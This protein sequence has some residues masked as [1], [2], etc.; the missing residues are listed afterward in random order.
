M[1]ATHATVEVSSDVIVRSASAALAC[2]GL[3]CDSVVLHGSTYVA[4][5][6][7]ASFFMGMGIEVF[8]GPHGIP[9]GTQPLLVISTSGLQRD[10]CKRLLGTSRH[11][12]PLSAVCVITGDLTN[13]LP[14][15]VV[16][17][18]HFDDARAG[19]SAAG[20]AFLSETAV[21]DAEDA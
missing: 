17:S 6:D 11:M 10:D 16:L 14:A 5:I 15:D 13:P 12:H 21:S 19:L 4:G 7:L 2:S 8:H 1:T 3:T 20:I 18:C 9:S